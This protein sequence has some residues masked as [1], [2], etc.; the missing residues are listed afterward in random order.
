VHKLSA[1]RPLI[2][3]GLYKEGCLG[4]EWA[5]PNVDTIFQTEREKVRKHSLLQ[6]YCAD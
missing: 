5:T 2:T 1:I 4:R 3:A 6:L